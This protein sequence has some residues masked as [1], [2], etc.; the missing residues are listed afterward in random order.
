MGTGG[1][2]AALLPAAARGDSQLS[3]HVRIANYVV[4]AIKL[5]TSLYVS[6]WNHEMYSWAGGTA[7]R[8]KLH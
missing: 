4:R 2:I 1:C 8:L 7:Q 3:A 5:L 6:V